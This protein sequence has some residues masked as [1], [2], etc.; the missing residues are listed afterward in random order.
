MQQT[1]L[2]K[3]RGEVGFAVAYNRATVAL[4]RAASVCCWVPLW[5]CGQ[6]SSL[7]SDWGGG[8]QGGVRDFSVSAEEIS[9]RV[10][11]HRV[12]DHLIEGVIESPP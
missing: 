11:D 8:G 10:Y 3:S 2:E 1:L 4:H 7:C 12:H 6:Q 5:C 9:F